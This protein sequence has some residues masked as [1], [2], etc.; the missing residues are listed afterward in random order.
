VNERVARVLLGIGIPAAVLTVGF[1]PYLALRSELPSRIASNFDASGTPDSSM[2]PLQF[3]LVSGAM[4][5]V[6]IGL[7]VAVAL[8]R[9]R[10]TRFM[11]PT[12]SFVGGFLAAMGSAILA[13]T[14]IGQRGLDRWQDAT[15]DPSG[16]VV[17]IVGGIL[18]GFLAGWLGSFMPT[19]QA[20]P[21]TDIEPVMDLAPGERAVWSATL[22]AR[23]P[24]MIGL[25]SVLLAVLAAR[26]TGPAIAIALIVIAAASMT[27]ARIRVSA[28]Q[29]GLRVRYGF[30]GWP[31]TAVPLSRIQR[32]SAIDVRPSEWG[33][34]GY[35]GSLT[36]MRSA[37]VV[38]RAGPGIRLDLNDGKVFVVTIDNPGMAVALLNAELAR[39]E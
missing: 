34:W 7:C 30:T 13:T 35:R 29:T 5:L 2:T 10:L 32:V 28:D 33:G 20:E 1:G 23:W 24:L 19:T 18:G 11:A 6:G 4:M 31:R 15:L 14:A 16:L 25:V 38:I 36:L 12:V 8:S 9:K 3:A 26:M 17:V 39:T 22:F 37:A 27:F 21:A